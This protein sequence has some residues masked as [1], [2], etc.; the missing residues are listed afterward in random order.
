MFKKFNNKIFI[1]L[2]TIFIFSLIAVSFKLNKPASNLPIVAIANWGPHV[3]LLETIYGIKE[4]LKNINFEIADANFESSLIMQILYKLKTDK[5]KVMVV[6]ATPVAQIA[7]N[8]IKDIPVV[9]ADVTDPIEAGL[10]TE[11]NKSHGNITGVSDAQDLQLFLSFAKTLLP[12]AKNIGILYSTSEANDAALIKM[13]KEA[14][15]LYDMQVVTVGVDHARDLPLRIQMLNGKVDFIYVGTSGSIQPALPAIVSEA[16]RMNI[17]VFN[18][19]S[20][21]VLN[22]LAVGSM[23]VSHRKIGHQVANIIKSILNGENIKNIK[24]IYPL[25]VDHE[26]FVSKKRAEQYGINIPTAKNITVVE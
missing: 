10:L 16:D 6:L 19:H 4:E 8:V 12:H 11:R 5:P 15:K 23:G 21:A 3:S 22:H 24:P 17:P 25:A 18:A 7:K 20:D 1:A 13:M 26:G 2:V 14:A 9:F